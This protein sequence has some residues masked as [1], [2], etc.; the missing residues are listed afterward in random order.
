MN[1]WADASNDLTNF[2][3][4]FLIQDQIELQ[5]KYRPNKAH[6]NIAYFGYINSVRN[7]IAAC[8]ENVEEIYFDFERKDIVIH[9]A[10]DKF[11]EFSSLSDGQRTLIAMVA[12]IARRAC[13]LNP[14]LGENA[15]KDTPGVVLIDELDLHLH[16]KWQRSIV[17]NLKKAFPKIQFFATTHSPQIIGEVRTEE[18]IVLGE[19]GVVQRPDQSFGLESGQVLDWVM[20][21]QSRDSGV[22]RLVAQMWTEIENNRF[23]AARDVIDEI[24]RATNGA[25]PETTEA[26]A[27]IKRYE[28]RGG[29]AAE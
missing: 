14:H 28:L 10:N 17:A 7:A 4:W 12:D 18:L 11:L 1:S 3:H 21:A 16:P 15:V 29:A 2:K 20:G 9:F 5:R 23:K 8:I 25:I 19:D 26:K 6:S 24:E 13:L 22:A 27:A